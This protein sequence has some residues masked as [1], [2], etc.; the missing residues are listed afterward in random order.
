LADQ[1]IIAK[2]KVKSAT[3]DPNNIPRP[4]EEALFKDEF[5]EINVSG[6]MEMIAIIIKP[7]T[8]FERLKP[9]ANRPAYL[10]AIVE[11]FITM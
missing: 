5:I 1:I 7:T 2:I 10:V 4:K 11:P 3:F 6:R 9:L 8:Y